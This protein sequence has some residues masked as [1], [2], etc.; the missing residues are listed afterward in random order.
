MT[1]TSRPAI[2][3][4]WDRNIEPNLPAPISPTRTGLARGGAL[5]RQAVEVHDIPYSAAAR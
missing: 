3:G 4:T 1:V 5:L 2:V